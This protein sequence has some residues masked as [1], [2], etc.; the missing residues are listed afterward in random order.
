MSAGSIR[1][2]RELV[3]NVQFDE[4]PPAI[5]ELLIAQSPRRGM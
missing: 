5:G 1:S 4:D 2:I 3:I